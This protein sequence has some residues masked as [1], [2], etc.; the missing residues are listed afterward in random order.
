VTA[1]VAFFAVRAAQALKD[2][3]SARL[4]ASAEAAR[5]VY[6]EVATITGLPLEVLLDGDMGAYPQRRHDILIVRTI[7]LHVALAET[8][9][10][11][12]VRPGLIAGLSVGL[13]SAAHLAGCLTLA[14][15][16]GLH[17]GDRFGADAVPASA[18]TC[19]MDPDM[20][21]DEFCA[22]SEFDVHPVMDFGLAP[23]GTGHLVILAGTPAEVR[24]LADARL[25]PKLVVHPDTRAS[26][27]PLH[28]AVAERVRRHLAAIPMADP[29]VPITDGLCPGALT[30]GAQVAESIWRNQS[31]PLRA[32]LALDEIGARGTRLCLSLGP[33][34]VDQ[35]LR[36]PCPVL[37]LTGPDDVAE[38]VS[39][40]RELHDE[41]GAT[42]L[43]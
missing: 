34:Q 26:H 15:A 31:H 4:Y 19:W 17:W 23:N 38:A 42:G 27:T 6:D 8:L 5:R 25:L 13:S 9:A 37:R 3:G 22:A 30:T 35:L 41:V 16:I 14:Q 20:D 32:K 1:P 24:R 10:A 12:G 2:I 33:T 29:A 39:R 21:P 40:V 36:F 43:R 28:A 7:A 11:E 18:A